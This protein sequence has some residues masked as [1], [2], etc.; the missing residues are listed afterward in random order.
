MVLYRNEEYMNDKS[1]EEIN[2]GSEEKYDL[3]TEQIV[4]NP[5]KRVRKIAIHISR[6]VGSAVLFGVIA[7]IIMVLIN[8]GAGTYFNNNEE[9]SSPQITIPTDKQSDTEE[10]DAYASEYEKDTDEYFA[11][12]VE[13]SLETEGNIIES[14]KYFSETD[15]ENST[16][17]NVADMK[18][19]EALMDSYIAANGYKD[20][21]SIIE[22]KLNRYRPGIEELEHIFAEIKV[23]TTEL[24]KSI[25]TLSMPVATTD[26]LG[27]DYIPASQ[28]NEAE[29]LIV[30][31][32][33]RWFYVLASYE[34]IKNADIVWAIFN[35]GSSVEADFVKADVTTGLAIVK[36]RKY[37]LGDYDSNKVKTAILGNSYIVS[38]GEPLILRGTI[39]SFLNI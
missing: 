5:W 33:K 37:E 11:E 36:C 21:E 14:D 13:P 32:D 4:S 22:N 2:N 10:S 27:Q 7:G 30:A 3:Y 1:N 9:N 26:V 39:Y 20:I 38:Q 35:D 17:I 29:G 6:I 18:Q 15:S 24:N 19:F 25:V 16:G 28:V 34:N 8:M 23:K 12:E 31:E